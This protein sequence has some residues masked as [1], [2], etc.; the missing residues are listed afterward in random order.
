MLIQ[1]S[2]RLIGAGL[3]SMIWG[4]TLPSTA[5]EAVTRVLRRIEH[6]CLKHQLWDQHLQQWFLSLQVL[7]KWL[8]SIDWCQG[9]HRRRLIGVGLLELCCSAAD[10]VLQALLPTLNVWLIL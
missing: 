8:R 6:H 7:E 5:A 4:N 2:K 10:C 9:Q 3:D 1:V